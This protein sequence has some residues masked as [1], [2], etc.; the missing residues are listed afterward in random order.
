MALPGIDAERWRLVEQKL[1]EFSVDIQRLWR[2]IQ[3]T[4]VGGYAQSGALTPDE[5]AALTAA[6]SGGGGDMVRVYTLAI[7]G[8]ASAGTIAW[9][10]TD[11]GSPTTGTFNFDDDDADVIT[12]LTS[13]DSGVQ[14]EGGKLRYNAIKIKFTDSTQRLRI[15]SSSLTR[16]T[17]GVEPLP[18]LS[19]CD[20]PASW[21]E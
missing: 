3:Q 15:T 12:A 21:W 2:Q 17:Y 1:A 10:A 16:E 4:Q 5:L 19:Y 18:E 14:A 9:S 20:E 7:R 13:F 8:N 6:G 11:G